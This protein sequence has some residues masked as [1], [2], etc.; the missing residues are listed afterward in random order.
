MKVAV[1]LVTP[2]PLQEA[3][4]LVAEL[5]EKLKA[6]NPD[7][8]SRPVTLSVTV[9][10]VGAVKESVVV[11]LPRTIIDCAGRLS[12]QACGATARPVSAIGINKPPLSDSR[13]V[14]VVFIALTLLT[15]R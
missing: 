2:E 1:S 8:Q 13:R 9:P 6:L 5:A 11:W 15:F 14:F 4:N 10:A 3:S 12:A 7:A